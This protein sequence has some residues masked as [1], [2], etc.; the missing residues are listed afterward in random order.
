[1]TWQSTPYTLP[2]LLTAGGMG[3]LAL[4]IWRRRT[5]PG[6]PAA[7]AA[8]A[9]AWWSATYALE[10]SS[11]TLPAMELWD[12]LEYL[13]ITALPVAI[14][15]MVL[16]YTGHGGWLTRRRLLLISAIPIIT[17]VLRF[18]NEYHYLLHSPAVLERSGPFLVQE[19]AHGAWFWVFLAYTYLLYLAA[20]G[21]LWQA[22]VRSRGVYRQQIG[23]LLLGFIAPWV[24]NALYVLRLNP[25]PYVD[26]TCF[27]FSLTAVAVTYNALRLRFFAILPVAREAVLDSMDDGV[28]VLD[29]QDRV[30]DFNPAAQRI[31]GIVGAVR[32]LPLLG[33]PAAEAFAAYPQLAEHCRSA[34]PTRAEIALGAGEAQ[35]FFDLRVLP[36]HDRGDSRAGRLLILHD[37]TAAK[38]SQES[39]NR[40]SQELAR[41]Y[42]T[43][44]ELASQLDLQQLLHAVVVRATDLLG[45]TSGGLYLYRPE[46]D[47][48][49]FAVGYKVSEPFI[50]VVLQRGEG[51]SGKVLQSGAPISVE[52]YSTWPERAPVYDGVPFGAVLA[53]PV[54]WGERI[55]GVLNVVREAGAS[56]PAGDVRLLTLFANQAAVALANAQAY[57]EVQRRLREVEM[58]QQASASVVSTLDLNEALQRI[59]D[60]AVQAIPAAQKGSLHLLDEQRDALV[61]KTGHGFSREVME[62]ATFQVGEGYTGWAFAH[63]Q[64]IIIDNVK[65]D[66]RTKPIDL[67]EVQEEK[68]AICVPLLVKDKA[69]GTIT[70]DSTLSYG[71]FHEGDLRSLEAFAAQ[72]AIAIENA[73]LYEAAQQELAERKRAEAALR[74]SEGQYRTLYA[75][76]QRQ[77]QEL[78]LLDQVRTVMAR[79]LEL[80]VLFRT[81]VEAIAKTFGYALVS[82]YLLQGDELVLQHHVGYEHPVEKIP[83]QKGITGRVARTGKPVLLQDVD[84]DPAFIRAAPEI[85]SEVCVPLLD[86]G[87]VCGVLNIESAGPAP[88][89][90]ADLRLMLA[91]AEH[92]SMAIARARLYAA[93]HESEQRF[94]IAA[95]C[96]SDLIYEWDMRSGKQQWFG[97]V[98]DVLGYPPDE[99]PRTIEAWHRIIHPDDYERDQAAVQ[100]HLDTGEPYYSE[101]RIV[102]KDGR[103]R[104]LADRGVALRDEQ[105]APYKWI[106]A[107]SDITAR[108]QA[109]QERQ[110]LEAQLRQAQKMEAVGLLAGGVAHDFNNVLTIILGNAELGLAGLQPDQ[111]LHKELSTIQRAAQRGATLAQQLLAFS[112]RQILQPRPLDL[113]AVVADFAAVFARALGVQVEVKLDLMREAASVLADPGALEQV[114]MNL[115]LNARDA[116]PQGGTLS[117]AT[118][119]VSVDEEHA[120]RQPGAKAGEYVRLSVADTGVG[121]D[122]E[123]RERL[124]EPFF[125]TKEVGKGTGLGL[126]VVYGIVSQ[127]D[128]WI[129]V[130]SQPGQ[131]ARFE[132]YLPA[133][134]A[135][136]T[137]KAYAAVPGMEGGHET[138]L[139]AE[140]ELAVQELARDILEKLGY[141]VLLAANGAE[142]VEL[143]RA[144][145]ERID[146]VIL[147]AVM[148][149]LSGPRAYEEMTKLRPHVPVLF[150][151]GYSAEMARLPRM[152]RTGL[153]LL[154]KPFA[155]TELG[156]KVRETLGEYKK[157]V[158]G[159]P[160]APS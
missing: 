69:I 147:D 22:F 152:A 102:A 120:R 66:P 127:H 47:D 103:V 7:L 117:F 142:A 148:P 3:L 153:H 46:H 100:R 135:A 92:V 128:G 13:G 97:N 144:N 109:E 125:T 78:V 76:A 30:V 55:L 65:T 4:L 149:R 15:C 126:S 89:A 19:F 28:I 16:Q 60:A 23:V 57:A 105:G 68:S 40:R 52:D 94:R 39:L 95:Q 10:L 91:L 130:Y 12:K 106:G 70:L 107:L 123:T 146:L 160:A 8:L 50:G 82:I 96:T 84:S 54:K 98:A 33:R 14:L 44:L 80:P 101:F 124:F 156:R 133:Q 21:L 129:E 140:D 73:R 37:V 86:Q 137:G 18:T 6:V 72:A 45:G 104:Y 131:G 1:M 110:K 154:H 11:T 93:A 48:L 59:I 79:E 114:L 5:A 138:I 159:L 35:H 157:S 36:L 38:Q 51:L 74:E 108:V 64:P 150:I 29:E 58:L 112:R 77:A 24:A 119:R 53:V 2:L 34:G 83:I 118:A 32:E 43:A 87:Q 56:F 62:A 26:L 27:A 9:I 136:L 132:I 63:R 41:L 151:T 111:P 81:V 121:M 155:V 113:N 143:F 139:L 122:A 75:A 145:K 88:L 116:M 17:L 90:E 141:T 99:V 49:Q 158:N 31:L 85:I 25:L 67:P 115:S 20:F 71:A 61:M 134:G 42:D